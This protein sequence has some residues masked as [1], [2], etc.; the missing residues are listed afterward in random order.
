MEQLQQTIGLTGELITPQEAAI[1]YQHD[2]QELSAQ[3]VFF[4]ASNY[5]SSVT[6]TP[7]AVAQFYTNHLAEYRLPDRAQV[8]YVA[9]ELSNYLAAA[10]QKL[11]RTNLDNQVDMIYRQYGLKG[12]PDAKTPKRPKPKSAMP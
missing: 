3:I 10:E 12:V 1:A 11:G 2:H 5:L 7:A 4:S 8:S 6:A 9:F